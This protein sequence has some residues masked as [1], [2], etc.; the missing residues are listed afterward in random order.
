MGNFTN[1]SRFDE[2]HEG[3]A[4]QFKVSGIRYDAGDAAILER[5][6]THTLSQV[7]ETVYS[8]VITLMGVPVEAPEGTGL[9][10]IEY[11]RATTQGEM[12][13]IGPGSC[14]LPSINRGL[15]FDE[16]KVANYGANFRY[17]IIDF[18][19][20]QRMVGVFNPDIPG[21]AR[22]IAER[23]IDAV[24]LSE[25]DPKKAAVK[26]FF[27]YDLN[28]VS[29]LT[30][31]WLTGAS[32]DDMLFDLAALWKAAYQGSG[33]NEEPDTCFLPDG[34]YA[35]LKTTFRANSDTTLL[36]LFKDKIGV[37]FMPS[38]R[39]TNLTSATN[40]LSNANA[41]LMFK[42]D[43]QYVRLHIPRPFQI[44]PGTWEGIEYETNFLL[45]FAGLV[46]TLPNMVATGDIS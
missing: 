6:L 20:V 1:N 3:L 23:K 4:K 5:K 42:K 9:T 35:M 24:T 31:G 26:G 32:V 43:R 11:L 19:R 2:L 22:R 27:G 18:E 28:V 15:E 12:A 45:D 46:L 10:T 29:G 33:A 40:S 13:L 17:N 37:D 7:Q 41:P 38:P 30:G 21:A 25:G 8:K 16:N 36:A 34:E 14:D 44:L 39:L